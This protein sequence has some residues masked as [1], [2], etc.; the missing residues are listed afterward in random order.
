MWWGGNQSIS[1]MLGWAECRKYV[2]EYHGDSDLYVSSLLV[3]P[4]QSG[5]GRLVGLQTGTAWQ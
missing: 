3:A 2:A 1:E 4:Q 5:D